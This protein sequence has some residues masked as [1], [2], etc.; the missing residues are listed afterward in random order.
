MDQLS[1]NEFIMTSD[2]H[3][4][5]FYGDNPYNCID[6]KSQYSMYVFK[7]NGYI[8]RC[9]EQ[10][11]LHQLSLCLNDQ[12]MEKQ[13]MSCY[14]PMDLFQKLN[15]FINQYH[16]YLTIET[17]SQFVYQGALYKIMEYTHI[18]KNKLLRY[19]LNTEFIN[20]SLNHYTGIGYINNE[21]AMANQAHWGINLL[22][23]AWTLI[24]KRLHLLYQP[25]LLTNTISKS[26]E[27]P[28]DD[29]NSNQ[30][31]KIDQSSQ[32]SSS[33]QVH[34]NSPVNGDSHDWSSHDRGSHDQHSHD[35][36]SYDRHSHNWSSHDWGSHDQHSH[37]RHSH[38]Q[39][40]QIDSSSQTSKPTRYLPTGKKIKLDHNMD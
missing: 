2:K 25:S 17:Y 20:L 29:S 27:I 37:Y 26:T 8:Y 23:K 3:Y 16:K 32:V 6:Y 36:S 30:R 14:L 38:D 40:P 12:T 24:L 1:V 4:V 9:S 7:H 35:W 39:C 33:A 11:L 31:S 28:A 34:Q 18:Q 22:G 5:F 19:P 13:I 15:H 21:I 10:Y